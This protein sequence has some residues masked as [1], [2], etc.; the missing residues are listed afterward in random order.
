MQLWSVSTTGDVPLVQFGQSCVDD[1]RYNTLL[2]NKK[3]NLATCSMRR[4]PETPKNSAREIWFEIRSDMCLWQTRTQ[5][6]N[7][8][9]DKEQHQHM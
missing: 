2:P 9:V 1:E 4:G 7:T 8:C 3:R 6:W 5:F